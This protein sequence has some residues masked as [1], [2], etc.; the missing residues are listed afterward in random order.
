[1]HSLLESQGKEPSGWL[2]HAPDHPDHTGLSWMMNDIALKCGNTKCW[3][4]VVAAASVF[5]VFVEL[6]WSISG[7]NVP[8]KMNVN[9]Y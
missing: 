4:T 8:E 1:M 5:E 2:M 3:L 9:I 6:C 7:V